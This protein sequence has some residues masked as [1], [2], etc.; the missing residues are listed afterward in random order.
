MQ[1]QIDNPNELDE[2]YDGITY[3]KSCAVNRMLCD[4]IGIF[5]LRK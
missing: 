4:Y 1:V 3:S 5:H 2:I